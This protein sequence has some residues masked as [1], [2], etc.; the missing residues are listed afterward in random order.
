M[1]YLRGEP[2]SNSPVLYRCNRV[3]KCLDPRMAAR[4]MPRSEHQ[5]IEQAEKVR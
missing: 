5:A 3:S 2:L 4:Q 1:T